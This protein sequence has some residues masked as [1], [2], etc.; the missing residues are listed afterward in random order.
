MLYATNTGVA[1]VPAARVKVRPI[2]LSGTH[3][4]THFATGCAASFSMRIASAGRDVRHSAACLTAPVLP[5]ARNLRPTSLLTISVAP[6]AVSAASAASALDG[7]HAASR[8][9]LTTPALW[10]A[11]IERTEVNF[12]ICASHGGSAGF[13]QL[14]RV[15]PRNFA[16]S[17]FGDFALNAGAYLDNS[18]GS[19]PTPLDLP[20]VHAI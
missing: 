13:A 9:R 5:P 17:P 19:S 6:V 10:R 18:P 11:R 4:L 20:A 8:A 12:F 2:S 7:S 15:K 14:L 3:S 16:S 1:P